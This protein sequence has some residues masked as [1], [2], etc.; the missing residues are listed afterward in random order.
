MNP[1]NLHSLKH[2]TFFIVIGSFNM[3][4]FSPYIFE[5]SSEEFKK[6]FALPDDP[7]MIYIVNECLNQSII[8]NVFDMIQGFIFNFLPTFTILTL[9]ILI[10]YSRGLLSIGYM[11]LCSIFIYKSTEFFKKGE[12]QFEV[13]CKTYL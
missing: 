10:A 5:A 8:K 9:L 1:E 11:I 4:L 12:W 3:F 13:A 2:E 7:S 6:A